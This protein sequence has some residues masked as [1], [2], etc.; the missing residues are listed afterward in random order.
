MQHLERSA[1]LSDSL[2]KRAS[3]HAPGLHA[4]NGTE[5][6]SA[7]KHTVPHGFMDGDGMLG[8]SRKQPLKRLVGGDAPLFQD[9]VEHAGLSIARESQTAAVSHQPSALSRS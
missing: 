3:T 7:G 5:P 8:L 6:L 9:F 1:Q 4:Q 2:R